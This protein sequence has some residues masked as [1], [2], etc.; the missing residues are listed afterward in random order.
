MARLERQN[1]I[2]DTEYLRDI[3]ALIAADREV[4]RITDELAAA[5]GVVAGIFKRMEGK[6]ADKDAVKL[7]RKLA[8]YDDSER[9]RILKNITRYASLEQIPLFTPPS[10]AQPQGAMFDQDT[11]NAQRQLFLTRVYNDGYNS[12]RAGGASDANP[13][14]AGSEEHQRWR[15]GY[16]DCARDLESRGD[17]GATVAPAKS[18]DPRAAKAA[19]PKPA[20]E[21]KPAKVAA[22]PKPAAAKKPAAK[23]GD[24]I[25]APAGSA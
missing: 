24:P 10:E 12:K 15:L 5:R 8:K 20:A 6:G 25:G 4:K 21:A 1:E 14:A 2:S 22:P 19:T 17:Q 23:G 7:L 18:R 11:I 3:E 13:H 9:E 16:D